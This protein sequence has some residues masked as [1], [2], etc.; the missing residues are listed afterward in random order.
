MYFVLLGFN[1]NLLTLNQVFMFTSS[2]FIVLQRGCKFVS[3]RNKLVSSAK[4]IYFKREEALHKSLIYR[5][6]NV[7]PKM[8]P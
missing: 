7:G 8:D 5:R 6:N 2:S 4:R 1:V 3:E